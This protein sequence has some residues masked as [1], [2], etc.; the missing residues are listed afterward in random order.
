MKKL[1][2]IPNIKN[3]WATLGYHFENLNQVL[4]EFIDNALSDYVKY[5][6][7]EKKILITFKKIGKK[8]EILIEDHGNGIIDLENALTLGGMRFLESILNE[9]GNGI[10]HGLS[11]VDPSNTTW[12]ILTRGKEDVLL[13][14]YRVIKAPYSFLN[15]NVEICQGNCMNGSETGTIIKFVC[16]YDIFKT[17]R[18]PFGSQTSQ[19]KDLVDLSVED[20]GAYYS[21]CIKEDNVEISIK[22]IDEKENSEVIN[23]KPIFPI[24]EQY[25]FDTIQ[26]IDLGNGPINIELKHIIMSKNS[27]TKKFYLKNMRS[28]GV[29]IRMN[30]RLLEFLGFDEIWGIKSHPY[31]NGHLVVVNLISNDR[32]K[33]PRT[34]TTKT[35]L[36]RS[37]SK[38]AFLFKWIAEQIPLLRDEKEMQQNIKERFIEQVINL[39]FVTKENIVLDY[40]NTKKFFNNCKIITNDGYDLYFECSKSKINDLYFLEKLWDEEIALNKP[41]NK[42]ILIAEEHPVAVLERAKLINSKKVKNRNYK[43]VLLQNKIKS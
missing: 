14:Q 7:K 12:T 29:E 35:G 5:P 33:L 26:M 13:N 19:F 32:N 17:I 21:Y 18:I 2:L 39:S 27:P 28:S 30:G 41:I 3:Y 1:K 25:K 15:M 31:Y 16:S 20:L 23:I 24:I 36:N 10:K 38:T 37:D 6:K 43:I 11:F 40:Y 42:M 8:V 34:R 9:H 4:H 22:M